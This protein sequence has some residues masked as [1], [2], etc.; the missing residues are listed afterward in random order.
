MKRNK[1]IISF[2]LIVFIL[3]GSLFFVW[4]FSQGPLI[5]I[6]LIKS[7]N[8][9]GPANDADGAIGMVMDED[10]Y[11][12]VTGYIT[13]PGQGKDIWLAK[14]DQDLNMMKNNSI[15]GL[16][17]GDDVGY[18]LVFDENNSLFLLGYLD[19]GGTGNDI[20]LARFNST[21]LSMEKATMINGPA[22][23]TDDGYGI[24]YNPGDKNIYIAGTVEDPIEGQNIY[25]AKFYTN[26]TLIKNVMFNGP[27]SST[28]KGRFLALDSS[29][30]LYVSGSKSRA[31][32]GYDMWL[33][34]FD[35]NFTLINEIIIAGPTSGEDKGYGIVIDSDIIYL[36]GTINH[37]SQ[38]FNIFLAKFDNNLNQLKNVTLN[39][40]LNGEDVAYSLI[41]DRND[42]LIL[43][44]VYSESPGDSN[45][46][47]GI[48]NSQLNLLTYDTVDGSSHGYD[49]GYG[50][51]LG[52]TNNFYVSGFVDEPLEN[53]NIWIAQYS[54][55]FI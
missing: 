40:P 7:T 55:S 44:G 38:G 10:G 3:I 35:T 41:L 50:V 26:L 12:Y 42:N 49:T 29:G 17:N 33:G 16:A 18:T 46:W 48:Y 53:T 22:S 52:T 43:T 13:I 11:L 9:D 4:F 31:G 2:I 47:V 45:I 19:Q 24:L 32:T 37:S 27:S 15:N 34:K 39:G 30:N 54:Q 51:I 23:G 6:Q 25:L 14:F 21:D 36:A 8:I 5:A 20:F 28:D 1:I